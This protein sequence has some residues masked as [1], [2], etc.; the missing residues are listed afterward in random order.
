MFSVTEPVW[1]ITKEMLFCIEINEMK[2]VLCSYD[3]HVDYCRA[4]M[5]KWRKRG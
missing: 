2:S 5:K 1:K 3:R 4:V